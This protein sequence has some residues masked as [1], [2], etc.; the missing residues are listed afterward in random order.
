MIYFMRG[1]NLRIKNNLIFCFLFVTL[2]SMGDLVGKNIMSRLY[3]MA[4]GTN[5]LF[6][7]ADLE[8]PGNKGL[9]P[10]QTLFSQHFL[11]CYFYVLK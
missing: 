3:K 4:T 8:G 5:G 2:Y 9:Q 11:N 6:V 1:N 10:V 7:L